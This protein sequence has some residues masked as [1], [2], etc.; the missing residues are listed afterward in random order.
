[1]NQGQPKKDSSTPMEKPGRQQKKNSVKPSPKTN[2]NAFLARYQKK[3]E[4]K[5][6]AQRF[7]AFK[8]DWIVFKHGEIVSAAS[9]KRR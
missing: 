9:N 4:M 7:D 2:N 5:M 1:M 8:I 6:D 3:K